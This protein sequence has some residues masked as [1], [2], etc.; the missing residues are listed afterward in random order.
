MKK[1]IL[2]FLLGIVFLCGLTISSAKAEV[3]VDEQP[4][5]LIF[6]EKDGFIWQI[7]F[8][9]QITT[10]LVKGSMP[11]LLNNGKKLL[12][13]DKDMQPAV[14]N[15]ATFNHK[16]IYEASF[17]TA[18]M[19]PIWSPSGKYLIV[20]SH[21]STNN[22]FTVLTKKGDY[23][24][25][26]EAIGTVYWINDNA[27]VYTSMHAVETPRPRGDGGG[28]A[29]GITKI[30]VK[31]GK[32]TVLL[33][34]DQSTDYQLFD[35]KEGKVRFIKFVATSESDWVNG[36]STMT[37]FRMNKNGKNVKSTKKLIPWSNKIAD[38]LP[39]IYEGYIV[40]DFGA[41]KSTKWRLFTLSKNF[42]SVPMIF[43]MHYPHKDTLNSIVKGYFPTW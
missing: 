25:T 22:T 31:S 10:K 12:Y 27:L 9:T 28:M 14:Y 24:T 34:P 38:I 23:K 2:L 20:N 18:N 15:L 26:F 41:F 39:S 17:E 40:E 1:K 7:S 30:N 33:M 19:Q 35:V 6:Y 29:F 3:I 5:D 4:G 11:K 36:T 21:T 37:Y 32:T 43:I 8:M 13:Y 42:D 16:V